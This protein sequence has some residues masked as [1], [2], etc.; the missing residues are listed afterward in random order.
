MKHAW[1]HKYLRR[2]WANRQLL[3]YGKHTEMA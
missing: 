2:A 1:M 3:W